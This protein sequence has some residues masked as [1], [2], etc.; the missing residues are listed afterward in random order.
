SVRSAGSSREASCPASSGAGVACHRLRDTA[1]AA[2][3][4]ARGALLGFSPAGGLMPRNSGG[5]V[6]TRVAS[7]PSGGLAP[8]D[9]RGPRAPAGTGSIAGEECLGR[10][11]DRRVAD[12]EVVPVQDLVDGCGGGVQAVV[13]PWL[14]EVADAGHVAVGGIQAAPRAALLGGEV[15]LDRLIQ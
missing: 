11:L 6:L 9:A 7:S 1:G 3:L 15:A 2:V 14:G 13:A 10:G 5:G 12:A 8:A 4:W